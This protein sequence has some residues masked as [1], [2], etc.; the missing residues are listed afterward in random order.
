MSFPLQ[1]VFPGTLR[2]A[3]NE[4]M[5]RFATQDTVARLWNRDSSLWP[6]EEHQ[7]HVVKSNLRWLDLPEEIGPY[8]A[9]VLESA[10]TVREAGMDHVVFVAMGGSNLAAAAILDFPESTIDK[11]VFLLDSTDTDAIRSVES[12][13]PLPR[14]LFVFSHKS[15]KRIET[16][17]LLLYFLDKLKSAGI[18]LPGKHFMA[19]TERNSYLASLANAYKFRD[20]FFDPPGISSRYSGL[21]HFSL[22]LTAIRGADPAQLIKTVAAMRDACRPE[23]PAEKNPAVALASFLAAGERNGLNR[24]ILLTG[25]ELFYVAYRIA[26]LT[27]MSTSS[28]GR[29]FIPI[30]TQQAYALKT[31]REKCLVVKLSLENQGRTEAKELTELRDAGVPIVEIKL[32]E[33]GDIAA[34]IFK[35][36]VATALACVPMGLNPFHDGNT[37]GSFG[38]PVERLDN[39]ASKRQTVPTATTATEGPVSLYAGG[40]TRRMISSLNLR[41]ALRTFLE[42]RNQESYIAILPFFKLIPEYIDI[43]QDLRERMRCGLEMPVQMSTG[44]RYIHALG[45]MYKDGPANGI[46]VVV[47]AAPREDLAIPGADYTF[48]ELQLALAMEEC[49]ALE[50][51]WKPTIRLHLA[52]GAEKGLKQMRDIVIQTVAQISGNAG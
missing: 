41:E 24:L 10:R 44:P 30:F 2:G 6:T 20:V 47:T 27:G 15:G 35:W 39:I 33:H 28:G 23:A 31:V 49:E 40:R 51:S 38:I 14:T 32:Q 9:R 3:W 12:K 46:F 36:E 43:L 1:K 37:Q 34:E 29:G 17:C 21:I 48:G 25:P 26:Q 52:E 4:E 13:L 11:R 45:R 16:H 22:F 7:M 50:N 19:L 18:E 8:V 5:Q 42:L